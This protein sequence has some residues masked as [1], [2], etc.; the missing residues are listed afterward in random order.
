MIKRLQDISINKKIIGI[1]IFVNIAATITIIPAL[2]LTIRG[3][4]MSQQ[5]RY[6]QGI[7]NLVEGIIEDNQKAI[8]NYAILFSKDRQVKDNL[9]YHT[10]LAGEREHPMR[11]IRQLVETF[12][13]G[14]IELT[15]RNGMVVANTRYPDIFYIDRRSDKLIREALK[16]HVSTGIEKGSNGFILKAV[17]PVYYDQDQL[18]GTLTTGIEM[19][20][21]FVERIRTLSGVD[22]GI[23]DNSNRIVI[24]T[25]G[26]LY[27]GY[28]I[29]EKDNAMTVSS[30]PFML[31]K[32]PFYSDGT[33]L[34]AFVIMKRDTLPEIMR[35]AHVT[36]AVLLSIIAIV[37]IATTVLILK[38][39]LSPIRALKEGAEKIGS[40]DFSH[41]IDISSRDEI[42][43]LSE[44]F[45]NMA[46]NLQKLKTME[47]KLHHSERLASIGRFTAGIAHEL[48]NPIANIMGM[49]N[50]IRRELPADSPILEDIDIMVSE[51]KRCGRIVRDLLVYTRQSPVRK[52]KTDI[53]QIIDETIEVLERNIDG[54]RIVFT[55]HLNNSLSNV[56]VDPLQMEQV[57]RNII[58]NSIQAIEREG[59]I[60]VRTSIGDKG[61]LLIKISDT[62]CGISEEIRE[63][64]FYPFFTTKKTGEGTGL[65]LTVCHSIIEQHN[66]EIEVLSSRSSGTTFIIRLPYNQS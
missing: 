35:K 21:N 30:E 5:T 28:T 37:S 57:I 22:I 49:L 33:V 42:G 53:N 61:E 32:L 65:G 23:V 40:G 45:N 25:L 26:S 39:I 59:E 15:D 17:A 3:G 19:N 43:S 10:E 8:K 18:I 64:I 44:V 27:P 20:A 2:F 6:L 24:S 4:F 54:K 46:E 62:G 16:G 58:L 63:K 66:G 56:V 7:K 51:A 12:N 1:I 29:P 60:S 11:A 34:G 31:I 48:N 52:E 38:K 9:F 14:F 50:V 55:K 47:E 41:R 36:V 13:V